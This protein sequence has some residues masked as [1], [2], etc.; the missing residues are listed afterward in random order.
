MIKAS[1]GIIR[2][3]LAMRKASDIR[4]VS[5][6]RNNEQAKTVRRQLRLVALRAA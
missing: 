3:H 1:E 5:H 2:W 6:L 4:A